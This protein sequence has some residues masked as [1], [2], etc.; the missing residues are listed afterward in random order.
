MSIPLV[1]KRKSDKGGMEYTL[2]FAGHWDDFDSFVQYLIEYWRAQVNESVDGIYSRRWVLRCGAVPI[3]VY[4]DSQLGNYFLREDGV[5]DRRL[6]E[7]IAD[8][9]IK[10]VAEYDRTHNEENKE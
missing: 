1:A 9:V 8:D 3:S 10:R 7:E 2:Y 6:L 4:H 5:D